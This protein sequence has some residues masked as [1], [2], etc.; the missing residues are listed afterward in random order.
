MKSPLRDARVKVL[1]QVNL[2]RQEASR[3]M[4]QDKVM[5]EHPC[6]GRRRLR[7]QVRLS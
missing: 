3:K 2:L 6:H 4:A 7:V 1:L 5:R